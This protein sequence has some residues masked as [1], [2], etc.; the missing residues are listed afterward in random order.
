M[1]IQWLRWAPRVAGWLLVPAVGLALR[2]GSVWTPP[3]NTWTLDA[4]GHYRLIAWLVEHGRLPHPDLLTDLPGGRD[5]GRFLPVGLY[6]VAALWHGLVAPLGGHD[7]GWSL[8]SLTAL[9]GALVAWPVWG[10]TR[11]LGAGPWSAAL[12][13]LV[14]ATIPAHLE[15]TTAHLLRYDGFGTLLVATHLA[16]GIAAIAARTPRRTQVLSGLSGLGLLAA[17][18][19]W[20]VPLVIPAIEAVAVAALAIHRAPSS[21]LR[22]WFGATAAALLAACASLE[23]LRAQRSVLAIPT[24]VVFAIAG[25]LQ[26]LAL[27]PLAGR[28]IT[29]AATLV[30]PALGAAALGAGVGSAGDYGPMWELLR[31]HLLWWVGIDRGAQGMTG[32]LL[33]V[34]ELQ[35]MTLRALWGPTGFSWLGVWLLAV[36]LVLWLRSRRSL[37]SWATGGGEALGLT[38]GVTLGLAMLTLLANRHRLLLAPPVAVLVGVCVAACAEGARETGSDPP[39]GRTPRAR[40]LVIFGLAALLPCLALM[41][42]D[43]WRCATRAKTR[44]EPGWS[45]ALAFARE[46]AGGRPV[47]SLWERGYELQRVAGC[48]TLSDGMLESP[49]NQAHIL[50]IARALMAPTA[51]SLAALGERFGVGLVVLPPVWSLFGVAMAAGDPLVMKIASHQPLTPEDADRVAIRMMTRGSFEPPF[52]PVFE[53]DGYRV[54]RRAPAGAP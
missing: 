43:S 21:A 30:L 18:C 36:P 35:P 5:I 37:R 19:V 51:D 17:L 50:S 7:L 24:L 3:G 27:R 14:A 53:R 1:Q 20:R 52:E 33:T 23:Y 46:H 40:L 38:L 42:R 39:R 31:M 22:L 41:F 28:A 25:A 13:A 10:A 49:A 47:L 12:A 34:R 29:R 16:L 44:L 48:A 2:L 9:A 8:R 26:C 32:V 15:H 45:A 4:A 11:A 54:Y 6:H